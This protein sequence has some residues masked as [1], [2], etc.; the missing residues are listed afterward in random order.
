MGRLTL[1]VL[2]G[3]VITLAGCQQASLPTASEPAAC[4]SGGDGGGSVVRM[5]HFGV[6]I[7]ETSSS[8]DDQPEP[9]GPVGPNPQVAAREGGVGASNGPDGPAWVSPQ[10]MSEPEG[11][12]E[13]WY[14]SGHDDIHV[15]ETS[16]SPESF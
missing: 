15:H 13:K 8:P 6:P 11:Q 10:S 14:G 4:G 5:G 1:A 12:G 16:S 3:L 2:A 9:R 7:H